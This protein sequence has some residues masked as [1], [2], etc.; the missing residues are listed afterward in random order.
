M[1]SIGINQYTLQR[2]SV[3]VILWS[4]SGFFVSVGI[5]VLAGAMVYADASAYRPCSINSSGLSIVSCGKRSVDVSDLIIAGLF[6][7]AV[8][9]VISAL[10]HAVRMSRKA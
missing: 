8:L 2:R 4:W 1:N 3:S 6:I 5:M 9:L 7:G 10:T